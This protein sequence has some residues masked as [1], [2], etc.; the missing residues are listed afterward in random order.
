ME[1]QN[2]MSKS[3]IDGFENLLLTQTQFTTQRRKVFLE[4]NL[5]YG[6]EIER[7]YNKLQDIIDNIQGKVDKIIKSQEDD[8]MIAYKEQMAEIQKEL[9]AMKRK[10]DEEALR[11]KADEKK[12]ILEE[13][14]DYFREE[15]LR[16]D[17]LCQEQSRT[18]EEIKFKLKITQEE[19]QYY[20]GFVIDSKKENKALKYELLQLY[21]QKSEDQKIGQ[22]VGS[23]GNINQ[24]TVIKNNID[25][26]SFTQDG[27]LM[28]ANKD[29]QVEGS[30][31]DFSSIKQGQK[32]QLSTKIQDY[33]SS[34]HDFFRRDLSS[35]KR[36]RYNQDSQQIQDNTKQELIQELRSQLQKE[37][38]IIQLLKV[39]LSK[40]NCQRGELEQILLD[41]VNEMKKEV[42]NRQT[43]QKQFVNH[44]STS[45]SQ[46]NI[47]GII[48]YSQFTH[49]DKIQLLKR[50]ISSD[51]FL[52]QL[53]QIT[54]NNQIQLSTSL[55]LNEK[56]KIDA[57]DA[58][59]KFN[60]FKQLKFKQKTSQPILKTSLIKRQDQ[61]IV[62]TTS[63]FNDKTRELINQ[64]INA[65]QS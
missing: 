10:I 44:R 31:R 1:P 14:R 2:S 32:T 25:Y 8:F 3:L 49:T 13:E 62:Q 55:K 48:N 28:T 45:Y 7:D 61:E 36:S 35:Q 17:K 56:W 11:Q 64:I 6:K 37:R 54:F 21:K 27:T 53:Y 9:K 40:Q 22:R 29:E 19:K 12:R 39:E 47:E 42:L 20:E 30:K 60:N 52:H 23:V 57:D 34:Q 16:L 33:G 63:N 18:L 43:Q 4:D 41:C 5:K 24:R 46:T 65:D 26:R 38:Q 51:E 58:T 15:A 59:K 50:F